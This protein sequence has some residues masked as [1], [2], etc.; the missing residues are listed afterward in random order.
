M[1]VRNF[2]VQGAFVSL[3]RQATVPHPSE[4]SYA[5]CPGQCEAA[6]PNLTAYKQLRFA[7]QDQC[8]CWGGA[9]ETLE[10][11]VADA[12][13]AQWARQLGHEEEHQV[14]SE[15]GGYW[16]NVFNPAATPDAGYLQARNA[17]GSWVTPFDPASQHGFAQGSAATYL[18]MVPQDVQGL[19][20]AMG[21]REKAATRL[22]AFFHKPDGS[23]SVRGGD[24]L[25]YDPTNEPGIHAPW[26]YNA[27]GRP[28]K[29][30]ETVRQI[31]DTVYGTGPAGLPGNDDLGTMS[32]WYVFAALG[33]YPKA[34]GSGDLL[35]GTPVFPRAVIA[36]VGDRA[37]IT[38]DAPEASRTT[39]Y[40]RSVTLDGA[41]HA[42]SWV[43]ASLVRR[44]G[45][46]FFVVS[47]RADTGWATDPGSLPR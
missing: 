22:E 25:R 3:Y 30:Q 39:P 46:L 45:S 5:G 42:S 35:L 34:P 16:K 32:A 44:G 14:L 13:L 10:A 18:W 26:L 28:W 47:D 21:G 8:Y 38:I 15:R 4:L 2:D 19:A 33:V 24:A 12:A 11:S 20:T 1:G 29:T 27:L 43:D 40:V 23:W 36:A 9:A 37:E 41:P 31:V 17:D 6:R 7:P